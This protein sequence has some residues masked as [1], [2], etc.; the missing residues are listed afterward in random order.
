MMNYTSFMYVALHSKRISL[1]LLHVKAD[2]CAYALV[3][4][5]EG[6]LVMHRKEGQKHIWKEVHIQKNT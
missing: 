6:F 3:F 4:K 2:S 5:P 1:S